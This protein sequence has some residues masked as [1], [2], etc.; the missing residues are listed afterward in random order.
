MQ[1]HSGSFSAIVRATAENGLEKTVNLRGVADRMQRLPVVRNGLRNGDIISDGDIEYKTLKAAEIRDG[2]VLN[3]EDL[4][5]ST[6]RRTL[7]PMKPVRFDELQKPRLVNRGDAVTMVYSDGGMTLTARG[8]ALSDGA[9]NDVIKV[10]NT[11]SNRTVE[12][13]V[14][15]YKEVTVSH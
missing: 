2:T 14:S 13:R 4:I 3:A 15:N 10:S 11:G 8:K 5:G 12:A 1:P 7:N 9:M 6:P